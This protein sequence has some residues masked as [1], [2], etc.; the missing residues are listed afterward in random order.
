MT[1]TKIGIKICGL[2]TPDMAE[3]C[4][5]IGTD[6]IGCVFFPPSPRNVS[7]PLA[8]DICVAVAQK[9][10]TVGVFVNASADDIIKTVDYCGLACAQLHGTEPPETV[11]RLNQH[12]VTVIKS[13][14]ATKSPGFDKAG[15]YAAS[16]CL[17][18]CG[19]GT[20][21]GGNAKV[22]HWA[23]AAPIGQNYPLVLAGGLSP[24]N[25]AEA[26]AAAMPDAV[27]VSSGVEAAPGE[28]DLN[29]VRAFIDTVRALTIDT[30]YNRPVRRIF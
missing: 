9:V 23:D 10:K 22:W 3:A 15:K 1:G 11:D 5:K 14:F 25:I 24:A 28:K 12:G 29:K 2:T 18:E 27:D 19:Q 17:V 6:A 16:A 30:I 7:L 13:L 26:I 20:L 21:P 4:V 8:K